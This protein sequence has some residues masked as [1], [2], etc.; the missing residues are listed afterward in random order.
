MIDEELLELLRIKNGK[1]FHREGRSLEFKEQFN[2]AGL[3][4]YFRDFAAFANNRGGFLVFGVKDAP[5][6]LSGLSEKSAAAFD[7]VDPEKITGF[8]GK[9][10]SSEIRWDAVSIKI[11]GK[12]FGAFKIYEAKTKPVISLADEGKNQTLK[13]GDIYYRYGGRTQRILSAELQAIIGDR[14]NANNKAWIERVEQIGTTGPQ[15]ALVVNTTDVMSK[16]MGKPLVIDTD[17]AKKLQF[18]RE[19]DFDEKE[20][21]ATLKLIGD[22]VPVNAI[23]I[24]K[25]VERDIFEKYPYSALDVWKRIQKLIPGVKQTNVWK[26]INENGLKGDERYSKYNFRNR[27][28]EEKYNATGLVS[29]ATPVIYN[30]NAI[31]F[32]ENILKAL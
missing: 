27:Q 28:Q 9:L 3:A 2:L 24:E 30:E 32:L 10:F 25:E 19:G 26:A 17:L 6:E 16:N 29:N 7:S 22:V 12:K 23:E 20:G 14:I 18:I 11:D 13:N 31:V 8:L 1:L 5:R 21:A 4:D 15:N